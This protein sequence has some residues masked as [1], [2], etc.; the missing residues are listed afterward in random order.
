MVGGELGEVKL[1]VPGR[2]MQTLDGLRLGRMVGRWRVPARLNDTACDRYHMFRADSRI[3]TGFIGVREQKSP[4]PWLRA[5][6]CRSTAVM[7]TGVESKDR[8]SHRH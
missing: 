8:D 4:G 5:T 2:W 6:T 1:H 3:L 7:A